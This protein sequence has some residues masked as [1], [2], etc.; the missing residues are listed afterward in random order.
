MKK[1]LYVLAFKVEGL[2]KLVKTPISEKMRK[3]KMLLS[4]S[5]MMGMIRTRTGTDW[6]P[7]RYN[8]YVF[9]HWGTIK[10]H[11]F[12]C[13]AIPP[14]GSAGCLNSTNFRRWGCVCIQVE[15]EVEITNC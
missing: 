13:L 14:R 2:L 3:M 6:K 10:P 5:W 15:E 8:L 4:M 12:C 11:Q 1:K 7:R 9:G